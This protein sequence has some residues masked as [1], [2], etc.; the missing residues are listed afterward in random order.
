MYHLIGTRGADHL[1]LGGDG[2]VCHN[3]KFTHPLLKKNMFTQ[4]RQN[5]SFMDTLIWYLE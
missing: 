4:A 2:G 1:T 3:S 5:Y